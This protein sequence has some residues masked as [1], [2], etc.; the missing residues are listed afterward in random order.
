MLD[1]RY[2]RE[3]PDEVRAALAKLYTE[4]PLDEVLALD[5]RHRAL[6]AEVE[7]L[8]AARN[9]GSKEVSKLRDPAERNRRIAEMRALGDHIAAL[10]VD[11]HVER[12][13]YTEV[14]PP[15]LVR[16]E[17]LVGTA[18]L[19]KF[20][21]AQYHDEPSDL[22]LIPTAEVPVTNMHRDEILEPGALPLNYVAYSACFRRE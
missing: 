6:L 5:E 1:L 10:A 22:W 12:Q 15:Y 20:G 11:L 17:A 3:H 21:E 8:R 19:P 16:T 13:G 9:A 18:Q 14:Y 2:I 7:E 4:A